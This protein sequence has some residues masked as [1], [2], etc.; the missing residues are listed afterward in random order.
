[1]C[2]L[3][4]IVPFK[5]FRPAAESTVASNLHCLCRAHHLAKHNDGWTVERDSLTGATTWTA[6][7]GRVHVVPPA[8]LN[9]RP[10]A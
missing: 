6:P 1:D 3:D 5:H 4:H 9:I 2:D 7:G 10:A 8:T